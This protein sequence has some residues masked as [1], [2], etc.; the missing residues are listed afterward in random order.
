MILEPFTGGVGRSRRGWTLIEVMVATAVI[1]VLSIGIG[2]FL[3]LFWRGA[4]NVQGRLPPQQ[5]LQ[6]AMGLIQKDLAASARGSVLNLLPDPGFEWRPYQVGGTTLPTSLRMTNTPVLGW[7]NFSPVIM[8]PINPGLNKS[9]RLDS[10]T[11]NGVGRSWLMMSVGVAA[12][13]ALVQTGPMDLGSGS[14]LFGATMRADPPG[15]NCQAEVTITRNG[16][17]LISTATVAGTWA[18]RTATF[19][20]TLGNTYRVHLRTINT[21]VSNTCRGYFDDVYLSTHSWPIGRNA[22][23]NTI[24]FLRYD[25]TGTPQRVAYNINQFDGKWRLTR[26]LTQMGGATRTLSI[27]GVV[28]LALDWTGGDAVARGVDRPIGIRMSAC[29]PAVDCAE[30]LSA[31]IRVYPVSR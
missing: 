1:S 8:N 10:S 4:F 5:T 23:A 28:D 19:S 12:G 13:T 16:V 20:A 31:E 29:G 6:L 9:A 14:Y 17:D 15:G 3:S 18:V 30:P 11:V 27:P 25:N 2:H 7:W 22:P 26:S 24:G 21:T